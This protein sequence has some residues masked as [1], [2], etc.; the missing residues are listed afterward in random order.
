VSLLLLLPGNSVDTPAWVPTLDQ[1]AAI[2]RARTRGTSSR[3]ANVAGEQDMFTTT[4][5]PT[6]AQALEIIDIAVDEAFALTEGRAPCSDRLARSFR[7][8]ALYRA[9]MLIEAS[10]APEQTNGDTSAFTA[11]KEM[12][13]SLSQSVASAIIEQCPLTDGDPNVDDLTGVPIG[14][15]PARTPTTWQ[16]QF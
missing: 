7:V 11:F 15:V 3:D 8:A 12:W 1:L 9:A 2:L 5:R 6:R 16:S 13:E 4:T 14:R 10:Y